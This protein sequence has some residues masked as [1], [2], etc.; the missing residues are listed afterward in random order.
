MSNSENPVVQ[1]YEFANAYDSL[2]VHGVILHKD[3]KVEIQPEELDAERK[4]FRGTMNTLDIPSFF[5]YITEY[6]VVC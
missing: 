5:E 4:R 2:P 1:N 3:F 6:Q